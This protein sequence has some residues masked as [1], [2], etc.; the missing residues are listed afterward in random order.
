M[1]DGRISNCYCL[2]RFANRA[3]I[4]PNCDETGAG[5]RRDG[6]RDVRLTSD[7]RRPKSAFRSTRFDAAEP[8]LNAIL[9]AHDVLRAREMTK[10]LSGSSRLVR[11]AAK[12]R[13]CAEQRTAVRERL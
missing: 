8:G 10:P 7:P 2:Q 11:Q 6:D 13:G 1:S 5:P 12:I 9:R 4:T 3:A